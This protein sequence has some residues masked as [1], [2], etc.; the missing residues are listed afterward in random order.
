MSKLID[1]LGSPDPSFYQDLQGL[2]AIKRNPD[3]RAALEMAAGQF[4]VE[5]LQTVLKHMRAASDA[6][7][8]EEGLF[9]SQQQG[10][11]RDMYDSQLAMSM[12]KKGGLG[13]KQQMIEQLAP[14][15]KNSAQAV[16]VADNTQEAFRQSLHAIKRKTD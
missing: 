7:Q 13:I 16:V 10:F 3:Q 1:G 4:E 15:L 5:F 8:E 2:Q 12:V 9:S 14:T 11:Y 6:L